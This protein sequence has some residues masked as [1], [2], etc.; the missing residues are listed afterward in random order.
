MVSELLYLGHRMASK[1]FEQIS[2][3]TNKIENE[4]VT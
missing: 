4:M 2:K 1:V 3:L